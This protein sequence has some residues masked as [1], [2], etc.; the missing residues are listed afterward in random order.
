MQRIVIERLSDLGPRDW[1]AVYCGD[2]RCPRHVGAVEI[3][4][5]AIIARH[6]DLQLLGLGRR[7]RCGLCGH[8]PAEIRHGWRLPSAAGVGWVTPGER[9]PEAR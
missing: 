1:I 5:A 3:D 2:R 7:F 8:R 9:S 6:G 4:V